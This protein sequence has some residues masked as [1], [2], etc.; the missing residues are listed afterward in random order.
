MGLET[1]NRGFLIN[2]GFKYD[3]SEMLFKLL[4]TIF[5]A[6]MLVIEHDFSELLCQIF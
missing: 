5:R 2:S 3:F 6:F 4:N 1:L